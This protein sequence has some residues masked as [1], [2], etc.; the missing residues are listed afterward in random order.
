VYPYPFNKKYILF[1]VIKIY[2]KLVILFH[3]IKQPNIDMKHIEI[4]TDAM[5]IRLLGQLHPQYAALCNEIY[6]HI[7]S[8]YVDTVFLWEW[9]DIILEEVKKEFW[10]HSEPDVLFLLFQ[11]MGMH[12]MPYS[13]IMEAWPLITVQEFEM[14]Y[15]TYVPPTKKVIIETVADAYP[16]VF[17]SWVTN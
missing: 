13:R 14:E 5:F 12:N 11:R 8:H 15:R 9:E 17:G 2:F 10:Q 3:V 6:D 16:M 1:H 7:T 4:Q